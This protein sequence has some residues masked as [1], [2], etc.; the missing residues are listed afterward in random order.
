VP[1]ATVIET[2]TVTKTETLRN[3]NFHSYGMAGSETTMATRTTEETASSM[4]TGN[5]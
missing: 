1:A 5:S 2:I 4:N 3:E